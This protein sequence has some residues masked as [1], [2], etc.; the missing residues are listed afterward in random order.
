VSS[1][2]SITSGT[3]AAANEGPTTLPGVAAPL[4]AEPSDP[5]SV[6]WYHSCAVLVDAEDADVAAVVVAA[7]IDA[8]ADVQVDLAQV[9][10]FVQVLVTLG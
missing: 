9:V 8:A 3:S 2:A 10:Q 5:P 7:G 4:S 1:R 6:T